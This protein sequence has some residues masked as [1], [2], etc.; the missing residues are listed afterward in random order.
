MKKPQFLSHKVGILAIHGDVAEHAAVLRRLKIE[1]IEVRTANDF[2]KI[3]GLI[4]PGGEST[5]IADLA[6]TYGLIQP[7]RKFIATPIKN[8]RTGI[9]QLPTIFATCAGLILLAKLKLL[10]TE[11][12]R[13]AYGRQLDSFEIGLKIP[14]L[15]SRKFPGVFIRAPKILQTGKGVE[16]LAEFEGAPIFIQQRN[17]FAASFHPELMDDLRIHKFIYGLKSPR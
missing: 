13:N 8:L 16:V 17:I 5:T 14:I 1:P 4:I 2:E 10:N 9:C 15:G 6:T 12:K 3:E 11:V 7:L